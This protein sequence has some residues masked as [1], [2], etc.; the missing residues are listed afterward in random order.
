MVFCKKVSDV[1]SPNS[2][3]STLL[4][5]LCRAVWSTYSAFRMTYCLNVWLHEHSHLV[6]AIAGVVGGGANMLRVSLLRS[7]IGH[8]NRLMAV[9]MS[10]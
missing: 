2:A 6:H 8:G 4:P 10:S 3:S 5:G 1:S 7:Q 9:L